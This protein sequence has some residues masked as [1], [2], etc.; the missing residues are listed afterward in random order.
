MIKSLIKK[1]SK[2]LPRITLSLGLIMGGQVYA[3]DSR[4]DGGEILRQIE[5]DLEKMNPPRTPPKIE[6]EK[7]VE[8]KKSGPTFKV[9]NFLFEGNQLI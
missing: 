7:K 2:L 6:E 3:V 5:R 4:S 8:T 1:T 9:Q